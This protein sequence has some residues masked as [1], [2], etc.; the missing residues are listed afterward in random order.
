MRTVELEFLNIDFIRAMRDE[1]SAF[2]IHNPGGH[3]FQHPKTVI[4]DEDCLLVDIQSSN[5]IMLIYDAI[6]V[7]NQTKFNGML[8]NEMWLVNF[9]DTMWEMV[10]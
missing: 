9:L 8:Q 5:V 4:S 3:V 2:Q 1:R 6:K 7:E 10:A